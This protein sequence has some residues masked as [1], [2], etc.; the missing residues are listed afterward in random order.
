MKITKAVITA[1]GRGTRF[2]PV[3]K[4]YPKE[5]I[6]ILSKP[7]IQ[8]LVEEAMN[9]GITEI[10]IVHR[11]GNNSIE[12]YF[13]PDPELEDYLRLNNKL[14]FLNSLQDVRNRV[15][16]TFVAQPPGFTY[17]TG[18]PALAAKD[19]IQ[20]DPF[21]YMYGDDLIVE[22]DTGRYLRKMIATFSQY[23]PALVI[24]VKDVGAA[25]I[26]RYGSAKYLDDPK[27][28]HRISGMFE[29]L[30]ANEAPSFFGQ[31][32]RFVVNSAKI[33]PVLA[34]QPISKAN[35]LWFTDTVNTL[36]ATDVVLTEATDSESD[37]M[38]TGDPLNWLKTNLTIALQDERYSAAVKEFITQISTHS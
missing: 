24:S 17:G 11:F 31:G 8:Y 4:S 7:N 32:G 15:K 21:V 14:E 5:L 2:L 19:F 37:W 35:E 25:D 28:P 38:T 9:A 3:V 1:A 10:C 33:W 6:A 22:K 36:A 26:A 16:L 18:S 23:S 12:K 30:P 29:K 20:N 27:Y 13:N 34:V